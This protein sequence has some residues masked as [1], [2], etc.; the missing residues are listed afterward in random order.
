MVAAVAWLLAFLAPLVL[1][2]VWMARL[3]AELEGSCGR[4][5]RTETRGLLL[6][7]FLHRRW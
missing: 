6:A 7:P 5:I 2:E 1:E 3:G 4:I